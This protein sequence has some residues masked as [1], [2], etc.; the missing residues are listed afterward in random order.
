MSE[1]TCTDACSG[2]PC[3]LFRSQI[4]SI[5]S[6]FEA[7][8]GI[9]VGVDDAERDFAFEDVAEEVAADIFAPALHE[10]GRWTGAFVGDVPADEVLEV[11]GG[12]DESGGDA[13]FCAA[14]G[15][16]D[17]E[18]FAEDFVLGDG[19]ERG[20]F[21]G[22][23]VVREMERTVDAGDQFGG[24]ADV[25]AALHAAD[26]G[27]VVGGFGLSFGDFDE[28]VVADDGT[29]G[30]VAI[31]GDA[32]APV[33]QFAEDGHAAAVHFHGAGDA[34]PGFAVA[35]ARG[36]AHEAVEFGFGPT[37]AAAFGELLLLPFPDG[38]EVSDVVEGVA[39]L[40][41]GE[42][43][44]APFRAG[45]VG[46][47]ADVEDALREAGVRQGISAAEEAFGDLDVDELAGELAGEVVAEA[48]FLSSAVD[49][50]SGVV[51][52]HQ[53]PP[54]GEVRYVEGVDGGDAF[55]GGELHQTEPRPEVVFGDELGVKG[56]DA[57]LPDVSA[58]IV[59][60]LLAGDE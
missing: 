44:A 7:E 12:T 10:A 24:E 37:E 53:R 4:V 38:G 14:L 1:I 28:E 56:D 17:A 49:D 32:V 58:E 42:G 60:V 51:V 19:G 11:G 46:V 57:T 50:D 35:F 16:G 13:Q 15:E 30:S 34:S 47:D 8:G 29:C 43:S 5:A 48:D 33:E 2:A 26:G 27:S 20:C 39:D 54:G 55:G 22:E 41:F 6:A 52:G 31:G 25:V 59:E 45:F 21:F 18:D 36:V 23:L 3:D 40:F 9:G